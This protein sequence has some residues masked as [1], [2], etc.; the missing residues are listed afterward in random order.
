MKFVRGVTCQRSSSSYRANETYD[1]IKREHTSE[2]AVLK[3]SLRKLTLQ[4]DGQQK[5]LE[6]KVRDVDKQYKTECFTLLCF[7]YQEQEKAE[8]TLLCEE[9]MKE[10]GNR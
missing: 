4:V 2:A 9:L 1:K 6:Q 8:L 7:F 3:A 5:Q 10:L